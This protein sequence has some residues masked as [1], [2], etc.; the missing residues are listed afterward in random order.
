[1]TTAMTGLKGPLDASRVTGI[2]DDPRGL[3]IALQPRVDLRT[4]A[5]LGVEALVRPY[6]H[7]G[8]GASP[9]AFVEACE[10]NQLTH[11][12]T[13]QVLAR[14]LEYA[15]GRDGSAL[16]VPVAVNVSVLDLIDPLF[17]ARVADC[18]SRQDVP[19]GR[20]EI[21]VT[22]THPVPD[23]QLFTAAT[24][25]AGLRALGVRVWIDDFG[26]GW[27]SL[28]RLRHWRVDG[29]KLDRCFGGRLDSCP[30]AGVIV[31]G[32]LSMAQE[33]GLDTVIE[34]LESEASIAAARDLGGGAGQGFAIAH[35]MTAP[36]LAHTWARET[37]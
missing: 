11:R 21:E 20:L 5:L 8:T 24:T 30:R 25:I 23:A 32:L 9:G 13:Q 16:D 15:R 34:G 22:E 27:G 19:A 14:A 2:L 3:G 17:P 26:A 6:L 31:A 18:L 1:M 7:D 33:L 36:D 35:P 12:L 10:R 29:I 37:A 28:V 4:G